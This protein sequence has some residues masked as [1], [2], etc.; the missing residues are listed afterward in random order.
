M[1][2]WDNLPN[3]HHIDWVLKIIKQYPEFWNTACDVELNPYLIDDLLSHKESHL[4]RATILTECLCSI[5]NILT[6]L[7][8]TQIT[9][10]PTNNLIWENSTLVVTALVFNDTSAKYMH[11]VYQ[12]LLVWSQISSDPAA[13]MLLP[14][15][16]V[17]QLIEINKK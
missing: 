13:K 5:V 14:A 10:N 2:A 6:E 15:A 9:I 11:M 7:P 17:R 12:D 16:Q 8:R 3:A 1:N 4:E